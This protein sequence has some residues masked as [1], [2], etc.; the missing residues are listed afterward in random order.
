MNMEDFHCD[1][2]DLSFDFSTEDFDKA[3]FMQ[4]IGVT[5]EA[6]HIDEDGDLTLRISLVS[7]EDPPKHHAHLRIILFSDGLGSAEF[8]FHRHGH[9]TLKQKPPYLEEAGTWLGQFFKADSF[10]AS[11]DAAYQFDKRFETVIPLPFPLVVT[12]KPLTGLKVSGLSLDYPD[13]FPVDTVIL[14][15][16]R[17][18]GPYLFINEA[19]TVFNFKEFSLIEELKSLQSLVVD[20]LI[21]EKGD[22][23]RTEAG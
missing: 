3:R 9:K 21:K 15:K 19:L 22:A 20:G 14:Q 17:N 13:D 11:I 18:D 12:S 7:R 16:P 23:G 10:D 1:A 5:N 2:L 6:D 4:D 8:D